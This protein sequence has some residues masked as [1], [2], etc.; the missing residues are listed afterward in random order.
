MREQGTVKFWSTGWGF[1]IR[2]DG[3]E[4]FAH[5]KQ[6]LESPI[7]T[8]GRRYLEQGQTVEFGTVNTPKGVAAADITVVEN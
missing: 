7:S 6:L 1:I 8:D 5:W 4:V 3:S 2:Q